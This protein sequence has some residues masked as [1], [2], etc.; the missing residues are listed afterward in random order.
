MDGYSYTS[1]SYFGKV[2]SVSKSWDPHFTVNDILIVI[3]M[4]EI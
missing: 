4:S 1:T 2:C 3:Y